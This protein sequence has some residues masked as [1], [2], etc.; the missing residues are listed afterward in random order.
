M[1]RVRGVSD[2]VVVSLSALVW[3]LMAVGAA[4]IAMAVVQNR[5]IFA[6]IVGK[7]AGAVEKLLFR[8]GDNRQDHGGC[9]AQ[10]ADPVQGREPAGPFMRCA[11]NP[12]AMG[13]VATCGPETMLALTMDWRA[14]DAE[15]NPSWLPQS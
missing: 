5:Y 8:K 15:S 6:A 3:A 14:T 11:I 10:H 12:P 7:A 9:R 13:P 1:L 2:I 4:Q